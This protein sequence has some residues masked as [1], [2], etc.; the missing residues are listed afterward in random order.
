MNQTVTVNEETGHIVFPKESEEWAN[1]FI[2]FCDRVQLHFEDWHKEECHHF[3][4]EITPSFKGGLID[5]VHMSK[6]VKTAASAEYTIVSAGV[7]R[8]L[9]DSLV[10]TGL[11]DIGAAALHLCAAYEMCGNMAKEIIELKQTV[12]KL[13]EIRGEDE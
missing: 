4:V 2:A 8:R 6:F 12:A 5:L 11:F 3:R 10:T 13:T 9:V 7:Q 1:N